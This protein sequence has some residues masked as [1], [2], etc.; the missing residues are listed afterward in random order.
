MAYI[1]L[2]YNRLY[3]VKISH[4]C[5]AITQELSMYLKYTAKLLIVSA[6]ASIGLNTMQN[7]E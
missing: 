7:W 3:P 4:K 1:P 2:A 6:L 5:R